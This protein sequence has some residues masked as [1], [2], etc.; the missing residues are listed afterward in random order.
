MR[1]IHGG[2]EAAAEQSE[3]CGF[4]LGLDLEPDG[5]D[6]MRWVS[7]EEAQWLPG[8]GLSFQPRKTDGVQQLSWPPS[9]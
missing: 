1:N 5:L 7:T 2:G 8:A 3:V 6:R 9:Y 4:A